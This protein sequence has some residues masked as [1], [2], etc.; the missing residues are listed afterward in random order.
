MLRVTGKVQRVNTRS[1]GKTDES[2]GEYKPW[3]FDLIKVVDG[4]GELNVVQRFDRD[5]APARPERGDEV[6]YAV[7]PEVF[8]GRVTLALQD[9]W[10]LYAEDL[11][12]V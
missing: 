6:D 3:S 5:D 1:G 2:T 11:S 8:R 4:G 7:T 10:A 12:S 9:D